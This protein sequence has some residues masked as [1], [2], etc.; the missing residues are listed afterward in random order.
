MGNFA[1]ISM[2]SIYAMDVNDLSDG[3]GGKKF[4]GKK[5]A[6]LINESLIRERMILIRDHRVE[7]EGIKNRHRVNPPLPPS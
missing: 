2:W 6:A 1:L 5:K 3:E 7:L 4:K